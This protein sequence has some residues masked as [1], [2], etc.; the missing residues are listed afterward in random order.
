VSRPKRFYGHMNG[1]IASMIR[2]LYFSR[3]MNQAQLAGFFRIRQG[4]VSRIVSKQTWS[5][6]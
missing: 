1:V 4:S 3:H 5:Q 2:E 6:T